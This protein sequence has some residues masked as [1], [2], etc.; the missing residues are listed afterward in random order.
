MSRIPFGGAIIPG[1]TESVDQARA[2]MAP[3]EMPN[4]NRPVTSAS[5]PNKTVELMRA[6]G[7]KPVS[8]KPVPGTDSQDVSAIAQGGDGLLGQMADVRPTSVAKE[9]QGGGPGN[10][11]GTSG[12]PAASMGQGGGKVTNPGVT[13]KTLGRPHGG[14]GG[15]PGS[16]GGGKK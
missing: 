9:G 8:A 15:F 13:S 2:R 14:S 4:P 3:A 11:G 10:V 16:S 7:S 5:E 12:F 6:G 1:P